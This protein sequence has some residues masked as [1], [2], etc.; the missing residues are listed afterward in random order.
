MASL[1]CARN[2]AIVVRM[3]SAPVI[4]EPRVSVAPMMDWTDRHC[5]FFLRGFSPSVLL[6]TEMI[7]AEAL[8]AGFAVRERAD[9]RFEE[10]LK[11]FGARWRPV[12]WLDTVRDL[13]IRLRGQLSGSDGRLHPALAR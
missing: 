2:S 10:A 7:T 3:V 11:R 1:K 12:V 8:L 4:V 9:E 6:Y 13:S 5:R